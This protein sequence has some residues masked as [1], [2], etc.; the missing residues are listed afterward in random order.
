VSPSMCRL[1]KAAM[2]RLEW[3][4]EMTYQERHRRW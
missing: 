4:S 2:L 3:Q 1:D